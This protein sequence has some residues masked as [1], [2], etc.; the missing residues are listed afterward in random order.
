MGIRSPVSPPQRTAVDILSTAV[1]RRQPAGIKL[2]TIAGTG[3]IGL[4]G[5]RAGWRTPTLRESGR[6]KAASANPEPGNRYGRNSRTEPDG[7]QQKTA[8]IRG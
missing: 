4:T 2:L 6:L 1:E 7:E 3:E 5:P 8:I